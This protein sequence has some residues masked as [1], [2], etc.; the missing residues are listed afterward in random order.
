M[1]NNPKKADYILL[2]TCA[3]KKKEED[4]STSRIKVLKN[5]PAKLMVFGCLP[6][7]APSKF[8]EFSHIA[9]LAP[10]NIDKIDSYFEN[11]NFKFSETNGSGE[12]TDY[13]NL[14]SLPTAI[15][16]FKSQFEISNDFCFRIARH[17]AKRIKTVLGLNRKYFNLLICRGC[18][19]N[20]S[21][22]AIRR[23]IGPLKSQRV[24][25][26]IK[27]FN[28]GIN[29]GHRDFVILGD[30]VGAYGQ[31]SNN[32]FPEL[33][34]R[35][36]D[37]SNGLSAQSSSKLKQTE[38]IGFHIEELNPK[39]LI[40]YDG[41]LVE[42]ITSKQLRSIC[43]PI[44]S[45]SDRILKLMNRYHNSKDITDCFLKLRTV[46]PEIQ[47]LT[48]I[49]VG[50]PSETEEDFDETMYFLN[51]IH[52]DIVIIFPY[53]EKENT[54]AVKVRPKIPDH[55]IRERLKKAQKYLKKQKIRAYLKC[56]GN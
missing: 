47:L 43:C 25:Q 55:V 4:Y 28:E 49:I 48:H 30:D 40:S 52:F 27:Q 41:K 5:Y 35:L 17:A 12:I 24:E 10:K 53:H 23:A 21:Y 16:K 37:E 9:H 1:V 19:G 42:L 36:L 32:T 34:S 20:C 29:A 15:Q 3:F 39:W 56:V 8:R 51:K 22:C 7:I 44:Q 50:F 46:N 13:I 11:I 2:N 45:G 6:D 26:I 14:N 18:L 33:L 38:E 54:P 31:G